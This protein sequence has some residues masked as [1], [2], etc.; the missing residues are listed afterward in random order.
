MVSAIL[1]GTNIGQFDLSVFLVWIDQE[2]SFSIVTHRT[3]DL[4]PGHGGVLGQFLVDDQVLL[5]LELNFRHEILDLPRAGHDELVLAPGLLAQ[6]NELVV[7]HRGPEEIPALLTELDRL[8][9]LGLVVALQIRF[10]VHY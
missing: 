7:L 4:F 9:V 3:H 2:N 8:L 10:S 6:I 1:I 5:H